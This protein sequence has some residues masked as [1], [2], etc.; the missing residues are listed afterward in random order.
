MCDLSGFDRRYHLEY[1]D[2]PGGDAAAREGWRMAISYLYNTYGDRFRDVDIPFLRRIG[3]EKCDVL[4]RMMDRGVNCPATSSMGRLFDAVSAL[5]GICD[6]SSFE[7]EAAIKLQQ[8]AAGGVVECYDYDISGD[9]IIADSMIEQILRD[10]GNSV[11]RDIISAKFHNTVGEMVLDVCALL[12]D[13]T[14]IEK[15]LISGGCF[16]NSYL[17]KYIEKGFKELEMELFKHKKFPATDL[18][19]SIGQAVAASR[20]K[21]GVK[22]KV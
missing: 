12:S 14:G 2:Q 13:E 11:G 16:Q 17:V 1:V 18:N 19:I 6:V 22:D 8:E 15:V 20:V 21:E 9:E 4:F 5:L 3:R 10:M 7:A